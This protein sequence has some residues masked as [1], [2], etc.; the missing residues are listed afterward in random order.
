[1]SLLSV[2]T[3]AG[4]EK[5]ATSAARKVTPDICSRVVHDSVHNYPNKMLIAYNTFEQEMLSTSNTIAQDTLSTSKTIEQD[6]L[7]TS[8][9]T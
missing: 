4:C 2:S 1:M 9:T 7:Y 5:K 6:M 3:Q 8:K